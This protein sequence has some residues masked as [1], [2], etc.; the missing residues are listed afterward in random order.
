ML[1]PPYGV[2]GGIWQ[3]GPNAWPGM[4]AALLKMVVPAQCTCVRTAVWSCSAALAEMWG[5]SFQYTVH[6][7]RE[8]QKVGN[9]HIQHHI[10]SPKP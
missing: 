6:D 5:L 8:V 2:T 4:T 1:I 10:P 7:T 9:K 3:V